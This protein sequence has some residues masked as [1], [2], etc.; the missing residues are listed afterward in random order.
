[1]TDQKIYSLE[2]SQGGYR[3][4]MQILASYEEA[5]S[6]ADNLGLSHP[7]EVNANIPVLNDSFH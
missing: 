3:Y 7:E 4:S 1:M 6:H 2:Y 5:M